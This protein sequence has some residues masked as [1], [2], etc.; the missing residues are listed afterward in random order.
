M[1][2]FASGA[3]LRGDRRY[4]NDAH[5]EPVRGIARSDR[6]FRPLLESRTTSAL[7]RR[8]PH[9][10][11]R[12][13]MDAGDADAVSGPWAATADVTALARRQSRR[14]FGAG[15]ELRAELQHPEPPL[16]ARID[17]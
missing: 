7:Y 4:G 8:L 16:S 13:R 15:G 14:A 9:D 6:V 5:P 3:C 17:V 1:R 12:E 10:E 11:T 2:R